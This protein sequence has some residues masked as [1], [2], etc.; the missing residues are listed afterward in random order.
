MHICRERARTLQLTPSNDSPVGLAAWIV[1]KFRE[2]SDCEGDVC[3]SFT[4]DELF[5]HHPSLDDPNRFLI[6]FI[7]HVL[8]GKKVP[9]PLHRRRLCSSPV[10]IAYFPKEIVFPPREWVERG[11]NVQH[12]TEMP[13]GG[14]FA[15][16]EQ[17]ELLAADIRAPFQTAT[18]IKAEMDRIFN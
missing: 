12:W 18:A 15:A 2:R 7:S 16:V 8:R 6:I 11:Y 9:T 10:G 3:R 13:Q 1:E 4:R 14:H 5:E 17:L